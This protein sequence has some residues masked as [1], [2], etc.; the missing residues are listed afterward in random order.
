MQ[1]PTFITII[2]DNYN[3]VIATSYNINYYKRN[4]V[5]CI[6]VHNKPVICTFLRYTVKQEHWQGEKWLS[7]TIENL[8]EFGN[9]LYN[10]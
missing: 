4:S 7:N 5:L 10:N 1:L 3:K 9:Y 2:C 8:K 6:P